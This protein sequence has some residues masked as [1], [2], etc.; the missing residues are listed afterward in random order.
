MMM[1]Q[2]A[3]VTDNYG[4]TDATWNLWPEAMA[5]PSIVPASSARP[6][7]VSAAG[8]RFRGGPAGTINGSMSQVHSMVDRVRE[9]LPHMPD[10]LILEV[11][12]CFCYSLVISL[13]AGMH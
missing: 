12:F 4:R 13:D 2:F 5:G 10:E 11:Y 9:V 7:G 6:D 8:L 3:S 1:R